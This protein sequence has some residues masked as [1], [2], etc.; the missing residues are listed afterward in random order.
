MK[1]LRAYELE[2]AEEEARL[3]KIIA[4]GGDEHVQKQQRSVIEEAQAMVPDTLR[5]LENAVAQLESFVVRPTALVSV[6]QLIPL[7]VVLLLDLV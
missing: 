3:D 6:A 7:V 2:V 5:R 4:D 1:D